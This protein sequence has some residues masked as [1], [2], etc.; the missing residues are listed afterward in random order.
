MV[1]ELYYNKRKPFKPFYHKK[2]EGSHGQ[3]TLHAPP[4]EGALNKEE[5]ALIA[6]LLNKEEPILE[7][8]PEQEDKEG[9]QVEEPT[10][11]ETQINVLWD[12][13]SDENDIEGDNIAEINANEIHA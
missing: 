9:Y 10:K 12:F 5:L 7:V 11:E 13:H 2:I 3:I 6:S 1:M 8:E 4:N